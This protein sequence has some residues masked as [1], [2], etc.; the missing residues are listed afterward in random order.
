MPSNQGT[1]KCGCIYKILE[2]EPSNIPNDIQQRRILIDRA[3]SRM[4][5]ALDSH[6][7][8][9]DNMYT[10]EKG[11]LMIEMA[12][13]VLTYPNYEAN[14][15]KSLGEG[16]AKHSCNLWS[17]VIC[18]L[19]QAKEE[20]EHRKRLRANTGSSVIVVTRLRSDHCEPDT[21]NH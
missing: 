20:Q 8:N 16:K 9:L 17:E 7:T 12:R 10:K 14:Y 4:R 3:A 1:T 13:V 19:D 5:G 6:K 21:T 15:I 11:Y 18:L 2:L